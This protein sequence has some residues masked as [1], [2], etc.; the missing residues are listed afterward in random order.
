MRKAYL[1]ACLLAVL[2]AASA[3][4]AGT[5][6]PQRG[7]IAALENRVSD[8]AGQVK[9]LQKQVKGL[10]TRNRALER[11][12]V[13]NFVGDAC[14]SALTA[15][16]LQQTWSVIDQIAATAQAKTYFG[17]PTA[18]DDKRTCSNLRPAVPRQAS[19]PATLVSIQGLIA[20]LV[21]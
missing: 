4:S 6:G 8:L 16:A 9:T 15:D 14:A 1:V 20:W 5:A 19:A 11:N 10:Q 13:A 18:L 12:L 21:G 7:E 3:A 17:A 2:T